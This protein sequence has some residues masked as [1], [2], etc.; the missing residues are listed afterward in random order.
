MTKT[1]VVM[2][3]RQVPH[4]KYKKNMT[5]TTKYLAHNE[6]EDVVVGSVVRIENAGRKL[7]ANKR[8]VVVEICAQD[9]C[10]N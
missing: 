7:S 10:Q 1:A 4:P 8:H 3:K 6:M 9:G 2:V 5:V